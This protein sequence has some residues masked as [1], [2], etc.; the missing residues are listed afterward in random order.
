MPKRSI[1]FSVTELTAIVC[2]IDEG[3]F[4]CLLAS[5]AIEATTTTPR[6]V[7]RIDGLLGLARVAD[8]PERL[9]DHIGALVESEQHPGRESAAV[10]DE[11]VAHA[12][13]EELASGTRPDVAGAVLGCRRVRGLTGAVAV[14][15][16]VERIVVAVQEVPARDLVDVA[17]AVVVDAVVVRR[18]EDEVFGIGDTVA[19]AVGDRAEVGDGEGAV[20]VAVAVR[21]HREARWR[22]LAQVD[23]GFAWRGPPSL[24]HHAT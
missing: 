6:S 14:G 23:V 4:G 3:T 21:D 24:R 19:V 9:L 2:S 8:A 15:D 5:S 10:G 16:G 17:I 1:C 12:N 20:A 7:G 13:G 11:R 22:G 18:V